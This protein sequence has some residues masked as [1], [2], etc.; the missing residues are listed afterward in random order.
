MGFFAPDLTREHLREVVRLFAATRNQANFIRAVHQT[1]HRSINLLVF[2]LLTIIADLKNTNGHLRDGGAGTRFLPSHPAARDQVR[3][4]AMGQ[5]IIW[6]PI[7]LYVIEQF[8]PGERGRILSSDG[9]TFSGA[10]TTPSMLKP[11]TY[12]TQRRQ[13]SFGAILGRAVHLRGRFEMVA[14][15]AVSSALEQFRD[16]YMHVD[17]TGVTL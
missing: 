10:P 12:R 16:D 3:G 7:L 17:L 15:H 9:D 1:G 13:L 8:G 14:V 2:A 6:D 11:K 4:T 5:S